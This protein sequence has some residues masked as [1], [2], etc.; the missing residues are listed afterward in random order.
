MILELETQAPPMAA[1]KDG[2]IRIGGTRVTLDT[3]VTAFHQGNT[4][5]EIVSQFPALSLADVYAVI[6]YYL[7]HRQMVDTYLRVQE[8]A[9]ESLWQEIEGKPDYQSFRQRLLNRQTAQ[10]Q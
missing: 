9:G 8:E 5:E 10:P 3:I 2:V 6:A 7:N 1:D 4:A